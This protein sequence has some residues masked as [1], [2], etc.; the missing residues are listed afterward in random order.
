M[1]NSEILAAIRELLP[2]TN[3]VDRVWSYAISP[4]VLSK[5]TIETAIN[6]YAETEADAKAALELLEQ[7]Q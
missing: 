2:N 4:G 7:L 6:I 3:R 5:E 1:T